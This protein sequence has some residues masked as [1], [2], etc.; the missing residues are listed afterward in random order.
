MIYPVITDYSE[1]KKEKQEKT[2]KQ[3]N[4]YSQK[5]QAQNKKIYTRMVL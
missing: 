1:K 4:L 2:E 5:R 3:I